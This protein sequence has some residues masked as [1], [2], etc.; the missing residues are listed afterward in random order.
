MNDKCKGC[1]TESRSDCE[2][3]KCCIND[4]ELLFCTECDEFPCDKL[5][6]SVGVHPG[7]LKDQS[8]LP[9]KK[10]RA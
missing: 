5:T 2:I 8:V 1:G 6:R 10:L 4:K 7:W 9:L 3:R